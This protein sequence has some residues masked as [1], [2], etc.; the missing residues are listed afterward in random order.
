[1]LL[2]IEFNKEECELEVLRVERPSIEVLSYMTSAISRE[3]FLGVRHAASL[4]VSK[5]PFSRYPR[6][7]PAKTQSNERMK[8]T[9]EKS[10][11]TIAVI[12]IAA[13]VSYELSEFSKL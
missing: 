12:R 9:R 11:G 5:S 1:M 8:A 10:R 4:T 2:S 7:E 13:G 6:F 3:G